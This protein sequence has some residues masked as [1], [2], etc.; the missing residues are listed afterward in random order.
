MKSKQ[1]MLHHAGI[2]EKR[3]DDFSVLRSNKVMRSN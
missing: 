1:V 2:A 3:W